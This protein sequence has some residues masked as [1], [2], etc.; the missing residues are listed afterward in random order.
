MIST[1]KNR[2]ID[3]LLSGRDQQ[4]WWKDFDTLAGPSDEWVTAYV[5]SMLADV[6]DERPVQAARE[7]WMLLQNC[8]WRSDGWGYNSYVPADADSTVWVLRLAARVG[9]ENSARIHRALDFLSQHTR[10]DGAIATYAEDGP[11]RLF[12][13]LQHNIS[14][15]GWCGSHTCVTVVAAEL[16]EFSG[17]SKAL[18]YLRRTQLPDGSWIGYWWCDHEYTT[19]LAVEALA[20]SAEA[21][22]IALVE[23]AVLWALNRVARNG[24]VESTL[25]DGESAFAAAGCVRI[26][27]HMCDSQQVRASLEAA[28][29]RLVM[30]QCADGSWSPSARL[31]IPPPNVTD[32][33]RY[34]GWSFNSRGGGS[35]QVDANKFFTTATVLR[36]LHEAEKHL[37]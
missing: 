3:F 25:P 19:S 2:A 15:D 18:D 31:R 23:R 34:V 37:G 7:S 28:A 30:K 8:H 35:I 16:P 11:I 13:Q 6:S 26:L 14:F 4:G 10:S 20:T 22:D 29:S 32:P 17:R 12:T 24:A 1:A 36:S 21:A 5:S 9:A 33:E 27:T